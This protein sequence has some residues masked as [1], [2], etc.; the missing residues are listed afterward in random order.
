VGLS[1]S[2]FPNKYKKLAMSEPLALD[3]QLIDN[4]RKEEYS[5]AKIINTNYGTL[6]CEIIKG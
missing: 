6:I 3:I 1:I 2:S 5:V 4:L